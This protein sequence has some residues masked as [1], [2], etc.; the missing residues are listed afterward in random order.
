MSNTSFI[1]P[2]LLL[3]PFTNDDLALVFSGLSHP[4]VIRYYGVSF[5]SLEATQ[6]QMNW[7]ASI[8]ENETGI[9][10][11]ICSVDGAQFYGACG[12]NNINKQDR[13]AEIGYWLLP[14][15]QGKGYIMEALP[16]IIEHGFSNLHLHRIEA[17]VETENQNS[18]KVMQKLNFNREGTMKDC[19][20]K[21]DNYI[22]L[23]I[24]AKLNTNTILG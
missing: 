5:H 1:T 10:R 22:S 15:F 16:V 17:F 4:D 12:L 18:I 19:E 6:E 2:R 21:N 23:N 14:E 7:Y 3:R 20:I 24:Y 11:A 9:W 8:E 13:K